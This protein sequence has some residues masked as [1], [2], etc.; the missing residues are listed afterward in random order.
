M[1]STTTTLFAATTLA[2]LAAALPGPVPAPPLITVGPVVDLT[3]IPGDCETE[4]CFWTY[5]ECNGAMS[6]LSNCFTPCG[7][8][9][10]MPEYTCPPPEA[11]PTLLL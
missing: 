8:S 7:T 6:F 1:L 3:G 11:T 5:S 2:V 4:A 9:T 10:V